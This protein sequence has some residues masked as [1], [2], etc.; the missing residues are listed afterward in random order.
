M[1]ALPSGQLVTG[2]AAA[3]RAL[4]SGG[5]KGGMRK[6]PTTTTRPGAQTVPRQEKC[7]SNYGLE[8]AA[9]KGEWRQRRRGEEGNNSARAVQKG[10]SDK[11]C[12]EMCSVQLVSALSPCA[13]LDTRPR[14]VPRGVRE[15]WLH[16]QSAPP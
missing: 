16:V 6:G 7:S 10:G 2:T 8:K 3:A 5:P 13:F 4:F 9:W 11:G 14:S 1:R 12:Y 15:N